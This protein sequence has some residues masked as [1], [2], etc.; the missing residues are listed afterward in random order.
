MKTRPAADWNLQEETSGSLCG[1]SGQWCPPPRRA[2]SGRDASFGVRWLVL[3][4]HGMPP[5]RGMGLVAGEM[6]WGEGLRAVVVSERGKA[7][8]APGAG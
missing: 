2:S 1:A 5:V 3:S 6:V 8:V 4:R 7:M